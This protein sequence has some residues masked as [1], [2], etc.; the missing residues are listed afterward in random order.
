MSHSEDDD[1]WPEGNEGVSH[2]ITGMESIPGW[3]RKKNTKTVK[4]K[5]AWD[6]Q[7]TSKRLLY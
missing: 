6:T 7:G 1:I 2:Q 4:H 5:Y 3:G